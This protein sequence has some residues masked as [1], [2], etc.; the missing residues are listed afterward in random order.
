VISEIIIPFSRSRRIVPAPVS[1]IAFSAPFS[2]NTEQEL[3]LKDGTHVPDPKIVIFI[4]YLVVR[5]MS[6][7]ILKVVRSNR[8]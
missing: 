4:F 8:Y 1:N 5:F 6:E 7:H 3:R 2:I